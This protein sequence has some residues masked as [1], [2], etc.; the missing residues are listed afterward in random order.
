MGPCRKYFRTVHGTHAHIE[1][2]P[3][4]T[5]TIYSPEGLPLAKENPQKTQ[6]RSV[7]AIAARRPDRLQ[8]IFP[9]N[10]PVGT[11]I[12]IG[13]HGIRHNS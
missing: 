9:H 10:I 12:Q 2:Q 1:A 11:M 8:G 5:D 6:A 13:F 7:P 3:S 4:C